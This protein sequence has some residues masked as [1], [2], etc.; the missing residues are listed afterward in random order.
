MD[1]SSYVS[2]LYQSLQPLY[3]ETFGSDAFPDIMVASKNVSRMFGVTEVTSHGYRTLAIE[4]DVGGFHRFV[5][6]SFK[7]S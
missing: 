6:S 3:L 4:I 5:S 7:F 2:K 1:L